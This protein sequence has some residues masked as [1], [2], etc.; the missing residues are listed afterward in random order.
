MT[1]ARLN[2]GVCDHVSSAFLD[3]WIAASTSC[4]VDMITDA[5]CSPVAESVTI[6]YLSEVDF[7]ISP[8]IQ[9]STLRLLS[10]MLSKADFMPTS[11]RF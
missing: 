4:S 6:S 1:L 7:E 9:F 5:H 11:M 8:S 2:T 10:F 3:D